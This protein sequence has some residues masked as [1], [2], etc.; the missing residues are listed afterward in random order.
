MLVSNLCRDELG[1]VSRPG[2][3]LISLDFNSAHADARGIEVVIPRDYTTKEYQ[4]A[5][6][7]AL[8]TQRFFKV[9]GHYVPVRHGDGVLTGHNRG[10]VGV[11]HLEPFFLE[12]HTSVEIMMAHS[13]E[14]AFLT[15]A[16][17]GQ[18]PGAIVIPPHKSTDTGA[19]S[20]MYGIN[21]RD[22]AKSHLIPHLQRLAQGEPFVPVPETMIAS[23]DEPQVS[24]NVERGV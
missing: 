1:M 5:M 11:I 9:H 18:I 3:R 2:Q 4:E 15:A 16:T 20:E 10:A 14:Y 6:L 8:M 19:V 17:V 13:A 23:T 22:F 24:W 21:E 12:D 7:W